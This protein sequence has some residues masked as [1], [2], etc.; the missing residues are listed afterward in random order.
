M[1]RGGLGGRAGVPAVRDGVLARG[2]AL[3]FFLD[4]LGGRAA[5]PVLL[6]L[7]RLL[8]LWT[9]GVWSRRASQRAM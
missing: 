2:P 1:F 3:F 8:P 5:Y 7:S 6:L 9:G 4:R